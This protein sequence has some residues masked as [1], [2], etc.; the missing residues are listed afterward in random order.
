[1]G[2]PVHDDRVLFEFLILEGAQ[3]GL[4]WSTIL[5]DEVLFFRRME[6]AERIDRTL[7]AIRRCLDAYLKE[8]EDTAYAEALENISIKALAWMAP[9]GATRLERMKTASR[10]FCGA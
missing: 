1:V 7:S 3:A 5:G 10:I 4:S 8:L 9:V 2:T 6:S